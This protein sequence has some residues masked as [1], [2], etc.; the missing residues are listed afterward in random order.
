MDIQTITMPEKDA[1]LAY[2]AYRN[3]VR[4][5]HNEEDAAIM[6]GYRE[7]LKGKRILNLHEVFRDAEC[8]GKGRPK[9]AICRADQ[10]RVWFRRWNA[11]C[12]F[13]W[14]DSRWGDMG[15]MTKR[16]GLRVP[17][18]TLPFGQYSTGQHRA[19]VPIVPPQFRPEKKG[20]H[21]YHILWEVDRWEEVPVDPM[22]LKHL[23]GAMYAVL[24]VWDLTPMERSVLAETR[25]LS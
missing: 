19:I 15:R 24:A 6:R 11:A 12:N 23:G 21:L 2:H 5:R 13:V 10:K 16:T 22:L 7:L 9:L 1:R 17:L 20:L 14:S 18:P 25:R 4:Q 3:A 8:D